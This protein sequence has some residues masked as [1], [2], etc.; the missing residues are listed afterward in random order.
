MDKPKGFDNWISHNFIT[1]STGRDFTIIGS[2]A[3]IVTPTWRVFRGP[4]ISAS[5]ATDPCVITTAE[6]HG[7]SD[8]QPVHLTGFPADLAALLD[9][10]H[11]ITV[12][13]PTTFSVPVD[14]SAASV[15]SFTGGT[16]GAVMV[17]V[18]TGLSVTSTGTVYLPGKNC[19]DAHGEPWERAWIG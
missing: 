3:K 17:G 18:D 7:F 16:R 2:F 10:P 19:T 4:S 14:A 8:K 5:T 11:E 6:D 15:G 12:L 9:G 1:D 13:S